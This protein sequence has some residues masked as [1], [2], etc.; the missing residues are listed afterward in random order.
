MST[1]DIDERLAR[2]APTTSPDPER[3]TAARA[4]LD[5][6]LDGVLDGADDGTGPS[7]SRRL[8]DAHVLDLDA[9]RARHSGHDVDADGGGVPLPL[10][11]DDVVVPLGRGRTARERRTRRV[12][13]GSAAAGVVG[14]VAVGLALTGRP[15]ALVPAGPPPSACASRLTTAAHQ[16]VDLDPPQAWRSLATESH[17]DGTRLALMRSEDGDLTGFCGEAGGAGGSSASTTLW[18][19]AQDTVEPGQDGVVATGVRDDDWYVAWGTAGPDVRDLRLQADW[20]STDPSSTD[21][22]STDPSSTDPSGADR[23]EGDGFVVEVRSTGDGGWAV[24]LDGDEV[25]ADADVSLRWRLPDGSER[26]APLEGAWPADPTTVTPPAEARRDACAPGRSTTGVRPVIEQRTGDDGITVLANDERFVVCTQDAE[27]PYR[28]WHTLSGTMTDRPARDEA[29]ALGGGGSDDART[30]V[31]LAGDDVAHVWLRL[32]DGTLLDGVLSGGYW[33]VP[34]A[35]VGEKQW[36]DARL[37]WRL[38]DGTRH[39]SPT[40]G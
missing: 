3:L 17:D 1:A 9:A 34:G 24:L 29:I 35:G 31:G 11:D 5:D 12:L 23:A 14:V 20:S 19:D 33:L 40:F 4:V 8:G 6:V 2:L 25:P 10:V 18:P 15:P 37:V 38:E 36:D 13:L 39:G 22:S 27:S 30:L 28:A 32:P 7:R 21:P 26:T 16:D